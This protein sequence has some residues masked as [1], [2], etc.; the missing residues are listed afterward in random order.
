VSDNRWDRFD[1]SERLLIEDALATYSGEYRNNGNLLRLA[2]RLEDEVR[3]T[4]N[5]ERKRGLGE[6]E[7]DFA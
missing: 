2:Q 3:E 5:V 7:E 6:T 4:L 1:S